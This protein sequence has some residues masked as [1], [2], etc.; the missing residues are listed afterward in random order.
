MSDEAASSRSERI[1]AVLDP[2]FVHGLDEL[3]VEEVRRRRDQV[4]AQREFLSYVR[5]LVQGHRDILATERDRRA[6]NQP[7][8]EAVDRVTSALADQ[9]RTGRTRGEAIRTAIGEEDAGEAEGLAQ[10]LLG[11]AALSGPQGLGDDEL[12]AL[13]QVLEREERALSDQRI[14]VFRVHDALQDE[15]KKRYRQDPSTIPTSG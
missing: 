2:S 8:P 13:M 15:L 12:A 14:A 1:R 9:P 5:R 7:P 10:S 11:A 6:S 4:L 3:S